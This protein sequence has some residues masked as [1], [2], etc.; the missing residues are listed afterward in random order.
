M[1][2]YEIFAFFL[3]FF[4]F[5]RKRA[6]FFSFYC[7]FLTTDYTMNTEFFHHEEKEETRSISDAD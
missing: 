5:F 4:D 2:F 6:S 3:N 1:K 7:G